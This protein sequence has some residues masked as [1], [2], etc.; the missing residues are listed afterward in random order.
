MTGKSELLEREFDF[1]PLKRNPIIKKISKT[2][3]P[4]KNLF[5]KI[6]SDN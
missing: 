1:K 6:R 2:I 3:T 5:L 4:A